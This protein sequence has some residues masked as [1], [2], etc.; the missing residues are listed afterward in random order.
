VTQKYLLHNLKVTYKYRQSDKSP[1]A[2]KEKTSINQ[3]KT[4]RKQFMNQQE[5][6]KNIF[7]MK[8][9]KNK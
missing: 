9:G 1:R 7:L 5:G 2:G 3:Q 8:S 4:K 6:R